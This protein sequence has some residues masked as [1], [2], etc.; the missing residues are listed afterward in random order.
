MIFIYFI[1]VKVACQLLTRNQFVSV[2]MMM[3][4]MMIIKIIIKIMIK[5]MIKMIIIK[6]MIKMIIIR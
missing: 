5:I 1:S 3:I 2:Q 6:M 4:K